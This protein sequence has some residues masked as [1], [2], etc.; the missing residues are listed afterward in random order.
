MLLERLVG[1]RKSKDERRRE[2]AVRD[3]GLTLRLV[4]VGEG[5]CFLGE[6]VL[7]SVKEEGM[8]TWDSYHREYWL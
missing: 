1:L 6:D 7:P 3:C 4:F 8:K 2:Q 5:G